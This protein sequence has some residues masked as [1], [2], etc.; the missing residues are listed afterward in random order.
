MGTLY[1]VATPIGN[2]EDITL[3]ALRVLGEVQLIAA[4]DTRSARRLLSH[5]ELSGAKILSYTESNRRARIPAILSALRDGDVALVSEAGMPAISDPGVHLVEAASGAGHTVAPVPGASALT[6]AIAVSGLPSRWFRYLGFLPRKSA[7]RRRL[8]KE[9]AD[10]TETLVAFEAPHRMRASL[11]DLLETLGD[12]RIAVCREL[13]K[14]HEEVFRGVLSAAIEHF[15]SP[16]GEFTLVIEGAGQAT[17]KPVA[18]AEVD[19]ELREL[20]AAGARAREAVRE[21]AE[22]SGLSH[23]QVYRR[24][25]S[26][27]DKRE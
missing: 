3:R 2:L 8:L 10:A 13:T 18:D 9:L 1:L 15:V 7:Q 26:L 20:R 11:K 23:R 22:R 4:E 25:L 24:W 19:A 17:Q 14:L 27:G 16:R 12:R 21:V 5:F 6:A